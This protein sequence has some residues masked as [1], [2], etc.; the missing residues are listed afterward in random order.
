[1]LGAMFDL[2]ITEKRDKL[3]PRLSASLD[4]AR[5]LAALYVF[6]HHIQNRIPLPDSYGF[7]LR[8]GQE[9]VL[10]FFLLSGFV[11][12]ANEKERASKPRGYLTRRLRRI[13]P[14]LL[15]AMM[16]STLVAIDNGVF[17]QR[18]SW[19]ELLGTLLSLQDVPSLKPGVIT[20]SYLGNT[21]LWSLSYEVGFYLIFPFVLAA[22][23]RW[24]TST[25]HIVGL[26]CC[27]FLVSYYLYPNHFSRILAY[28]LIWWAG[29]MTADAYLSGKRSVQSIAATLGWLAL[30]C[31]I[32]VIAVLLIGYNGLGVHPFLEFR[33]FAF[34]AF[35]LLV[36]FQP[37]SSMLAGI[38][39]YGAKPAAYLAS[40]SYGVYVLHYPLVVQ[41][42]RA[43][44][45]FGL[46]MSIVLLVICSVMAD[47]GLN[48]WLPKAPKT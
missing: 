18:F 38:L 16:V 9:A 34:A 11:I 23:K 24:P 35:I 27:A 10:V 13:Y 8:F 20:P 7:L 42:N 32:S 26:S 2:K 29:A 44:G 33:H 14:T 19:T 47:R 36:V 22:W 39:F 40:I 21:P 37:Y 25:N 12:F 5:A 6:L 15:A 48:K 46:L 3:S 1:M 17:W 30:S 45:E 4:A 43:S 28:F 41:W 31:M